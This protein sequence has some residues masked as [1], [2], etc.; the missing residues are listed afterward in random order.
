MPS[1]EVRRGKT[2]LR[3][4]VKAGMIAKCIQMHGESYAETSHWQRIT[5]V[6]TSNITF[7][8]HRDLDIRGKK[9][10]YSTYTSSPGRFLKIYDSNGTLSAL[11]ALRAQ[12]GR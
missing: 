6:G 7:D 3:A 2:A 5:K 8:W 1:N 9:I 12:G 4:D 10:V 11:Y